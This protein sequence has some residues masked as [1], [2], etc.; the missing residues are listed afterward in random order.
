[1]REVSL[2]SK[3]LYLTLWVQVTDNVKLFD[4]VGAGH[5][6]CELSG[7]GSVL[8]FLWQVTMLSLME[9]YIASG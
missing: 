6:L 9:R 4:T 1:M 2:V 3:T 8:G 7:R 5:Y